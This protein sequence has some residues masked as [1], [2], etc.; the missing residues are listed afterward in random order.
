MSLDQFM[1][2]KW[3]MAVNRQ[4]R[5]LADLTLVDCYDKSKMAAEERH[6]VML[7]SAKEH[8]RQMPYF[9]LTEYIVES[10]FM[11]EQT[12]G[13]KFTVPLVQKNNTHASKSSVLPV[14]LD[15]ISTMNALDVELYKYA[16]DLFFERLRAMRSKAPSFF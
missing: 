16:K 15:R 6:R 5:M 11:F 10:Q 8:L 3:N 7:K 4:T 14:Q 12:F 2:C 9:G 13:I 1:D